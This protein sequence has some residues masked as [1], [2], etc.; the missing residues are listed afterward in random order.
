MHALPPPRVA[1]VPNAIAFRDPRRG[2]L[3]SGWQSCA[4]SAAF[5]CRPQGTIELT[6]DGGRTWRVVL[7]TPRPVVS[8]TWYQDMLAARFDDGENLQST[9]G[10]RTWAPATAGPPFFSSCPQG[11][12][13]EP[14]N[15][16]YLSWSL[17]TSEAGA[18]SQG[19]SVYRLTAGHGWKRVAYTPFAPPG[20]GYGGISLYGYP[21]GIAAAG[22]FGVVWESRGTLYVSRDGGSHWAALRKVAR[23][24]VDF[25]M[26]A[27]V[28]PR[29]VGFVLLALGGS[30]VRRLIETTDA[31][32]TW[33]VVRRWR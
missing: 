10:G 22:A 17:C 32:R 2:L 21:Q 6:G 8:V 1:L 29:G 7:R 20:R 24:E 5:G 27:S 26:S 11:L 4:D 25:G 19:K 33:R 14:S 28:L 18:G 9:N 31:G 15:P 16:P 13:Q 23:P 30:E 12:A 3:G